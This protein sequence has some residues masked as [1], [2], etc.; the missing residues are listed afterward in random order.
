M[1]ASDEYLMSHAIQLAGLAHNPSPNPRVGAVLVKNKKVIAKGYHEKAGQ[2]HAEIIA[3]QKAGKRAHGSTLY[4][5][6]EPCRLTGRTPPCTAAIIKAGIRKVIIGMRD[7]T[8]NG[9]G[10]KILQAAGIEVI[11]VNKFDEQKCREL[12]QIWLKN[13]KLHL[14]YVTLKLAFGTGNSTIPAKNKKWIT[15]SAAHR[16]VHLSRAHHDAILVGIN[17]VIYDNPRLTIRGVKTKT[18]PTRIILDPQGRL[19]KT[20]KLL[21]EPGETIQVT[22]KRLKNSDATNL[23]LPDFQLTTLLKKLYVRG[24]T[25]IFVE[26]G[27]STAEHFLQNQ[28]VDRVELYF[29]PAAK[30]T[31]NIGKYRLKPKSSTQCKIGPDTHLVEFLTTY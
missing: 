2:P 17:T 13:T 31:Q 7:E 18:Q 1:T 6:L 5:T 30:L 9:G 12:N 27:L 19:P 10:A 24:I 22:R 29:S 25:S 16:L 20:A 11:F 4:V 8:R 26:G 23:V 14:P 3:L 15:G 21:S 28:L